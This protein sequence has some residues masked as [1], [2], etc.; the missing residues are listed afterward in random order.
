MSPS[1]MCLL[2]NKYRPKQEKIDRFGYLD[3]I[4][5]KQALLEGK[6][7]RA[8]YYFRERGLE[9]PKKLQRVRFRMAL[10]EDYN[11]IVPPD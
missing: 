1:R 2:C 3:D 8:V 11:K 9:V 4:V 6:R 10:Y 7:R 5:V